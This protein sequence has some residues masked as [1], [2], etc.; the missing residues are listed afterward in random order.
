M[1]RSSERYETFTLD[2]LF[3]IRGDVGIKQLKVSDNTKGGGYFYTDFSRAV[4]LHLS[5]LEFSIK[6]SVIEGSK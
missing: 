2:R 3:P 5:L 4:N 1:K 6:S